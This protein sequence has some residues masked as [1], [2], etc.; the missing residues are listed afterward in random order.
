MILKW[1][2]WFSWVKG[3]KRVVL[4]LCE[5]QCCNPRR[6]R[7]SVRERVVPSFWVL[8]LKHNTLFFNYCLCLSEGER[9]NKQSGHQITPPSSTPLLHSYSRTFHSP[10]P[11]SSLL[12]LLLFLSMNGVFEGLIKL[13]LAMPFC[14]FPCCIN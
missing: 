3:T 10:L 11:S 6:K 8:G 13:S 7:N 14:S 5:G 1:G 2:K 9:R 4:S 12:L